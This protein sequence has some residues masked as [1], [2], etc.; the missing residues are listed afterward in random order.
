M[1]FTK[2]YHQSANFQKNSDFPSEISLN[3]Y[4]DRSLLLKVYKILS[5]KVQRSYVSWYRRLMQIWRKTVLLFQKWQEFGKFWFEHSKVSKICT[6]IGPSR[7][8]YITSHLK[9]CRGVIFHDTEESLKIWRKTGMWFGKWYE[10]FGKFSSEHSKISKICT[11]MSCIWPKYK[12]FELKSTEEICLMSLNIDA[13]FGRKLTC[14][15]KNDMRNFGKFSPEHIRKSKNL[16]IYW[17]LLF[18]VENIWA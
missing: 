16:V 11:L 18:K 2:G 9:K 5:K 8:K 10:E 12:V 1:I 7:A 6:L 15:F 14:A 13:K 17:V 4:F 3:L